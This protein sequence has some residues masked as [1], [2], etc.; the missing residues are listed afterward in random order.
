MLP[1]VM[2]LHKILTCESAAIEYLKIHEVFY[3]KLECPQCGGRMRNIGVRDVLRCSG[4][5]KEISMRAHT[6]FY[7]SRLQCSEI[8]HMAYYWLLG[9]QHSQIE[10]ATGRDHETVGAYC[11][12]FRQLVSSALDEE[13]TVI[14]GH[15][16]VVEI[17]ETKMGRRK[18]NRGHRVEGV[19]VVGGVERTSERKMFAVPVHDRTSET[20]Q[21]VISAHVN[22]GSIIRTDMWRGYSFLD[23]DSR[24]THE[25]VNHSLHFKDPETQVHTNTI[26]GTWSGMK[27]NIAP[28]CR[29][30]TGMEGHLFEFMWRRKNSDDL[31]RGFVNALRDVH[32]NI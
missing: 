19:W 22:S 11:G 16:I 28:R 15:N 23:T 4:C 27:R 32:Y 2:E 25:T 1:P 17:D 7:K 30:Q 10:I 9:L 21:R 3:S 20:L 18:H 26:E 12:Y 6:F 29:V 24:Y 8:L 31:W 5:S 13:D 14:G